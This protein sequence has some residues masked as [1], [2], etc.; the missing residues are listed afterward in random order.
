MNSMMI[1]KKCLVLLAFSYRRSKKKKCNNHL[2]VDIRFIFK[3][4]SGGK[5]V[6]EIREVGAGSAEVIS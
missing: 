3:T 6:S 4:L 2:I 1:V 5:G